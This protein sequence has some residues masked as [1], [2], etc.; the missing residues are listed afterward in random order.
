MH[1]YAIP[2]KLAAYLLCASVVV[3]PAIGVANTA[4]SAWQHPG[5]VL[6]R[7]QLDFIR[8]QVNNTQLANNPWRTEF[9][10]IVKTSKYALKNYTPKG[11]WAGGINQCGSHSGPDYGCSAADDDAAAAYT[12]AILWYITGDQT[13][14]KNSIN[15]LNAYGQHL[16]G[17]AGF[18]GQPCPGSVKTCSNGPLQAAWD[19]EKFPRAAEI[20]RYGL[21]ANGQ[22]AGWAPADIQ[23]FKSMLKTAYQP[24][25]EKGSAFNGNW[26][27]AMIDG[28]MSI[29]VFN[30]DS[31]LLHYAQAMWKERVPAHFYNY[32]LDNPR[33]PNTHAPFPAGR[34]EKTAEWNKQTVFNQQTTGVTQET[35]RDL[36]HTEDGFAAAI[37]AAE[38]DYIQGGTLTA[39]LY[40]ADG[41]EQRLVTALNLMTGFELNGLTHAPADFCTD[42]NGRLK[43]NSV[44]STFVIGYNAYHNRFR[45]PQMTNTPQTANDDLR[46]SSNTYQ[47]IQHALANPS[48]NDKGVHMAIFEA[49]THSGDR[50]DQSPPPVHADYS[51][52]AD[53]YTPTLAIDS[54][55]GQQHVSD[56]LTLKSIGNFHDDVSLQVIN[57]DHLPAG[58][59]YAFNTQTI[60]GGAGQAQLTLSADASVPAGLY[61]IQVQANNPD[62]S[63]NYLTTLTLVVTSAITPITISADPQTMIQGAK[64]P[65]FT[66]KIMPQVKLDTAPTCTTTATSASLPGSYP[67]RCNGA[68]KSGFQF[69]YVPNQLTV[70]AAALTGTVQLN[71]SPTS[72]IHCQQASDTLYIDAAKVGTPFIAQA[73]LSKT[74]SIGQHTLT[75]AST[76]APVPAGATQT[77]F[78]SGTVTSTTVM[79][80]KDSVMPVDIAYTYQSGGGGQACQIL[81][82]SIISQRGSGTH[83]INRFSVKVALQNYPLHGETINGSIALADPLQSNF[84]GKGIALTTNTNGQFSGPAWRNSFELQGDISNVTPLALGDNPLKSLIIAGI[85]C[86]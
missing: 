4:P 18:N 71:L 5:V 13:Y 1:Y 29:A 28:M 31:D 43:N 42:K 47:L 57:T 56:M 39:H 7:A 46:A 54:S 14:A 65:V 25:L 36:K 80:Q 51:L 50:D 82:A 45:D 12:Q 9:N 86:H 20:I 41:A 11:P 84:W 85:L 79:I 17:F 8:Q 63:L 3:Y 59:H 73:G 44:S 32:A 81:S 6:D 77:G 78:C 35:C 15:I 33:Y 21:D 61:P 22:H 48:N 76:T 30:E 52:L 23:Q 19:S 2:K 24:M 38:T 68:I 16:K 53:S 60:I 62:G 10:Y 70:T 55:G 34:E 74:L 58:V 75:L 40:T 72:D 66:Y 26:E 37:N 49:L 64:L 83:A 69:N 27:L 67:I